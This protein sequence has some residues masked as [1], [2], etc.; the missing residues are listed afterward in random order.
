MA[1][2]FVIVLFLSVLISG[3]IVLVVLRLNL[4]GGGLLGL[5]SFDSWLFFG[6]RLPLSSLSFLLLSLV[7]YLAVLSLVILFG[8]LEYS[9]VRLVLFLVIIDLR[10]I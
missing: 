6:L 2:F 4:F 5:L 1:S 8:F 9:L 7:L 10:L 3:V